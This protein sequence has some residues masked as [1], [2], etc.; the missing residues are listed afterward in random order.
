[1]DDTNIDKIEPL[2]NVALRHRVVQRLLA[3]IVAGKL[4]AGTH[5]VA[6]RLAERLGVSATPIREG[7]VELEQMGVVEILHNR[8][9]VAKPF[10]HKE[11][12][13]IFHL[14]RILEREATLCAAGRIDASHL[15]SL[16]REAE[17][18]LQQT[19]G[20]LD[21]WLQI[22]IAHNRRLH[23]LM[24]D[25]CDNGRLGDEIHRYASLS[26]ALTEALGDRIAVHREMLAGHVDIIDALQAGDA[27]AAAAA[28]AQ[29]IDDV[30]RCMEQTLFHH[31][32][33]EK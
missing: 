1:M 17:T 8:G 9:A 10:S 2:A 7:L 25:H 26:E 4:S 13:E 19:P 23:G 12:R 5:L 22:S 28:M 21:E 15:P 14:R 3:A 27:S 31:Q 6:K 32:P 30:G 18:L 33:P 20:A 29:H 11:L 24:T 16:R